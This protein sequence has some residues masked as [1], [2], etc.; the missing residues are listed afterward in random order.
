M[1]EHIISK[2]QFLQTM[3]IVGPAVGGLLFVI[4]M[5]LVKEPSRQKFNAVLVAGAGAAYLNGGLGIWEFPYIAV[6]TI[7]AFKGLDSYRYIGIAWIM[8]TSWDLV[9]H[10]YAT[11]IWPWLETSSIGCAI[12]D[13]V[14]A[15]W[16]FRGAPSFFPTNRKNVQA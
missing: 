15:I 4:L 1:I 13:T 12:F 16:F 3:D 6:A 11:P 9:H 10:F 8:H 5:S 7:V 2:V 14:I